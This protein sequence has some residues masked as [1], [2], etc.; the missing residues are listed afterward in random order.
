MNDTTADSAIG[1][2]PD[3]PMA[4]MPPLIRRLW[5]VAGYVARENLPRGPRAQLRRLEADPA[6]IPPQVFWDLVD[7]YGI[8]RGEEEDF[9]LQ[10]VP[11]MVRHP[12]EP[13]SLPGAALARAGVSA[14]RVERWLRLD[15]AGA[16]R[17]AGRLLSHLGDGGL[18]WPGS[19]YGWNV[20]FGPLLHDWTAE[21]RRAFARQFFLSPDYRQRKA[22]GA[23]A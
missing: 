7:R 8:E 5:G 11:L 16:R 3:G 13:G 14:A 20:G 19:R 2:A 1:V 17:E 9:W 6:R 21:Q 12:H 4:G 18:D 10:V 22:R 23:D 15:R